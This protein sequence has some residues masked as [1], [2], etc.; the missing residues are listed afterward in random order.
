[1][2]VVLPVAYVNLDSL[3]HNYNFAKDIN[4]TLMRNQENSRSTLNQKDQQ[5]QAAAQEFD[6]KL[7]NNAF[8]SDE[9]AKQEQ[10]R[11]LKMQ[12]EYQQTAQR[13]SQEFAIEQQKLNIELED[14]IKVHI[15]EFNKTQGYQIIFSNTGTA[16][17]LYGDIKYDITGEVIEFLNN[18]YGPAT[19]GSSPK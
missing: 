17:I 19:S 1:S 18:R 11:I 8:L 2:S 10:Q 6:R 7:R 12:E 16:N 15:A 4:E 13:L 14:T 5:L 9:R 3:L